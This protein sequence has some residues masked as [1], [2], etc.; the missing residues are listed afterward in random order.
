[1][2]IRNL[3]LLVAICSI[4]LSACSEGGI[5]RDSSS[6]PV[7]PDDARRAK[8]GKITGEGG[9]KLWGSDDNEKSGG[10]S[11]IGV[12][13]FLWRATL[14]TLSFI[15]LAQVDPH[16]GVI[17]TDWYEDPDAR[18][19]RFKINTLILGTDL[20]AD[21]LRVSVFKQRKT[22][23]NGWE[24]VKVSSGLAEELEDKILT[25]ARELRINSS[26]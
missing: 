22:K 2:K 15:P 13:S 1:M 14:D 3:F 18:G 9:L 4:P 11:G 26:S 19:E 12:N 10:G 6:Y 21:G 17:I 20:R 16:G 25:R 5:K 24:D 7:D 8:R 23:A